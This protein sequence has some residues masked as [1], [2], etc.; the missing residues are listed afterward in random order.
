MNEQLPPKTPRPDDRLRANVEAL[1]QLFTFSRSEMERTRRGI[2]EEYEAGYHILEDDLLAHIARA[3]TD[4][5]PCYCG[6]DASYLTCHADKD[7][8][9]IAGGR[10]NIEAYFKTGINIFV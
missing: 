3:N 8:G 6:D 4:G 10:S 9:Y 5:D 1:D 2:P 7:A